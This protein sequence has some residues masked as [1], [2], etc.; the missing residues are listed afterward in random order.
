MNSSIEEAESLLAIDIGTIHTRVLL[1]DVVDGQYRF[2]GASR[3]PSTYGTP[4]Y[5]IS[6]G[7][8]FALKHL[9]ESTGHTLLADS[10]LIFPGRTDGTGIDQ[11]ILTFSA[12]PS[13][14]LAVLGLLEEVS[15]ES[16]RRLASS[17]QSVLVEVIGLNDKR[18]FQE[19]IDAL[20]HARPDLILIAGGTEKGATR[21]VAKLAELV[22]TVLQLTPS[23]RLPEVIFA[24]NQSMQK[25]VSE[26]LG[27]FTEVQIA[28]NLR[29][30]IDREVLGPAQDLLAK[31]VTEIRNR[32]IGGLQ[33]YRSITSTEPV[34]TSYATGRLIRYLSQ[35]N[36]QEKHAVAVDLGAS[37]TTL[38]AARAG[39]LD[40]SVYAVGMGAGLTLALQLSSLNAITR[41][42]SVPLPDDQVRDYLWQKTLFPGSVPATQE[43]LAIEQAVTRQ[44]LTMAVRTHQARY[45]YTLSGYDPLIAAGA[46]IT[47]SSPGQAMLQLLDGLQPTRTSTFLLDPHGLAAA[48]GATAPVNSILPVQVLDSNAF[49]PL[50]TVITAISSVQ[51]GAHLMKVRL[52]LENGEESIFEIRK[53]SLQRLPIP[54]GQAATIHIEALQKVEIDGQK[55]DGTHSFR[56]TGGV[57]GAVIDTRRRPLIL[58]SDPGRRRDLLQKWAMEIGNN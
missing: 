56:V 9:Q 55:I 40:L 49:L 18:K 14:R 16:T 13:L 47:D 19:Q 17:T 31:T 36:D 1:F 21:S 24:G 6:E 3:F 10:T 46:A 44:I 25:Y 11:L 29:P 43:T 50:G 34:P 52:E 54:N 12:G 41:W 22:C 51:N 8:Y 39:K 45:Q 53:G 26:S 32:Q 35:V 4:F 28:P 7:L 5:D 23:D 27:K 15:L 42:L 30:A 37:N 58:P 20:L 48:L 33:S 38:A 2:L 57:C